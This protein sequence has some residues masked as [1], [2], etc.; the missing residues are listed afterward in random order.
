MEKRCIAGGGSNTMT[1]AVSLHYFPEE[2]RIRA[3]WIRAGK[4]RRNRSEDYSANCF[5]QETFELTREMMTEVRYLQ[6]KEDVEAESI[7]M[8][9]RASDGKRSPKKRLLLLL[10][11]G[12]RLSRLLSFTSVCFT[13]C[14]IYC[15]PGFTP[16]L[17][18]SG[19][20]HCEAR[21]APRTIG[22]S[23]NKSW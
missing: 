12:S 17:L 16:Y 9:F 8:L 6:M 7:A 23:L 20:I 3:A 19:P 10:L 4:L 14:R 22:R 1:A 18:R 5:E 13:Q 2:M 21:G 11:N 15:N